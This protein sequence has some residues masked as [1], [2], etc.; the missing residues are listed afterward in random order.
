ME[1]WKPC[2][3]FEN[4]YEV[5]SLGR[6]RRPI[7][8]RRRGKNRIIARY[9][10]NLGYVTAHLSG[11]GKIRVIQ[12]HRLVAGAF[13]GKW[14]GVKEVNHIDGN[15]QNNKVENLEYVTASENNKHAFRIG[16][17]PRINGGCYVDRNG[18]RVK[19]VTGNNQ[20]GECLL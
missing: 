13:L 20:K 1:I 11:E 17:R 7:P 8:Y 16:L 10:N 3:W 14:D 19:D 9:V 4:T 12:V 18:T 5:S 2:P 6:V 15:K